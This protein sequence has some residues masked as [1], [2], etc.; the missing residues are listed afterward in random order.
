MNIKEVMVELKRRGVSGPDVAQKIGISRSMAYKWANYN[1]SKLRSNNVRLL[2]DAYPL[3]ARFLE[4]GIVD[5][6]FTE[7][8]KLIDTIKRQILEPLDDYKKFTGSHRLSSGWMMQQEKF[9]LISE[10]VHSLL[11]LSIEK[12]R[13]LNEFLKE[14]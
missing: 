8:Y 14:T 11:R 9:K 12:V 5:F 13:V 2:C 4:K 3:K 10:I 7:S 1:V 6:E